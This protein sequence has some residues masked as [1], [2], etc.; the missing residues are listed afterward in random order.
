MMIKEE[1][2]QENEYTPIGSLV[3]EDKY[4]DDDDPDIVNHNLNIKK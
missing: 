2:I 4:I 3:E 1:P